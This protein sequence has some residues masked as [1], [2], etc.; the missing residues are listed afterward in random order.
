MEI[1]PFDEPD[2]LVVNEHSA[3]EAGSY[4]ASSRVE[5]VRRENL[6]GKKIGTLIL[7]ENGGWTLPTEPKCCCHSHL[8]LRKNVSNVF[9]FVNGRPKNLLQGLAKQEKVRRCS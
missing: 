1:P 6:L 3:F 2:G 8:A 5:G 9:S 4:S 7:D